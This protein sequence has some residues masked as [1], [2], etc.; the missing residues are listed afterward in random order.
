L[1]QRKIFFADR[2]LADVNLELPAVLLQMRETGLPHHPFSGD[3][4]GDANLDM[5]LELLCGL[6][7]VFRQDL[8]NRVAKIETLTVSSK[9]ERFNL[10]DAPDT[11]IVK[12]VFQ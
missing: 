8:W 4:P 10:R 1:V 12:I 9:A 3:S 6:I 11:L 7:P 5:R 2:I